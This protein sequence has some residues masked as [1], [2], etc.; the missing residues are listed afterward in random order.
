MR[1]QRVVRPLAIAW[2]LVLVAGGGAMLAHPAPAAAGS[3]GQAPRVRVYDPATTTAVC[4]DWTGVTAPDPAAACLAH[5]GVR[6][7]LAAPVGVPSA[8]LD[9]AAAPV[10][11]S[12][13]PSGF[14]PLSIQ[15]PTA[16]PGES[17]APLTPPPEAAPEA[18]SPQPAEPIAPGESSG[19]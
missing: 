13:F 4:V 15:G 8:S 7:W 2:G 14:G 9:A 12:L 5:G 17:P 6:D 1:N 11:I 16:G 10:A 18:P 3:S 19:P